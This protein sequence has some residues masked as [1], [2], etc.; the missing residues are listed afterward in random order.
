M[1]IEFESDETETQVQPFV[2][3]IIP[4]ASACR[5]LTPGEFVYYRNRGTFDG[6]DLVKWEPVVGTVLGYS[7]CLCYRPRQGKAHI[8][9]NGE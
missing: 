6:I 2:P 9:R 7:G 5:T 1:S 4:D 8:I 3:P